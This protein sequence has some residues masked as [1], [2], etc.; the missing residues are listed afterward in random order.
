MRDDI[1]M[2]R[3]DRE[4]MKDNIEMMRDDRDDER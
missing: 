1:E 4:T 2:M 3:D